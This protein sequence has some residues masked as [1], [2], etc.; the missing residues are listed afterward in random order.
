MRSHSGVIAATFTPAS[1][2]GLAVWLKATDVYQDAARTVPAAIGDPV[3]GWADRSG[4][5]IHF[6][7]SS[8]GSRPSYAIGRTGLPSVRN[9]GGEHYVSNSTISLNRD[10]VTI[11][12]VFDSYARSNFNAQAIISSNG[13]GQFPMVIATGNGNFSL[14]QGGSSTDFITFPPEG[15]TVLA[16]TISSTAVRWWINGI[17]AA[18][19]Q[20]S[21]NTTHTITDL[22]IGYSY[23][24]TSGLKADHYEVAIYDNVLSDAD[25]ARVNTYLMTYVPAVAY[26][27]SPLVVFDGDSRTWGT[28]AE[29]NSVALPELCIA[30]LTG[31]S[32]QY[33]N[34]AIPGASNGHLSA[35]ANLYS[36]GRAKNIYFLSFGINNFIGAQSATSVYN[37]IAAAGAAAKAIGWKVVV[38]TI[39]A[40][41][42]APGASETAR[43][44]CNA[45][46]LADH[47]NFDAVADYGSDTT[48]ATAGVIN[49]PYTGDGLHLN[50]A[51]DAICAGYVTPLLQTLLA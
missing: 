49:P 33:A 35:L 1:L 29:T 10:N 2:S 48:I 15:M 46:L 9:V 51:G 42:D 20:P 17:A 44:N 34:I 8:N 13:I 23:G 36:A 7:Q 11:F 28:N 38:S 25:I 43:Q 16:L 47:T 41:A 26:T 30:G 18:S 40:S 31:P 50:G 12:L 6:A 39:V 37:L 45:M 22:S 4:N 3:G 24:F 27:N 19:G 21:S 14:Y 32:P 5:G